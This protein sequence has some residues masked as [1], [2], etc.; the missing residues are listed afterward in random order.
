MCAVAPVVAHITK[1]KGMLQR[2]QRFCI[3]QC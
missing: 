2:A 3:D 1:L